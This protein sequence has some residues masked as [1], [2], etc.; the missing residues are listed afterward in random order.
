MAA[1]GA[2]DRCTELR[3]PW[4]DM[5]VPHVMAKQHDQLF[6]YNKHDVPF[7]TFVYLVLFLSFS[8]TPG[9]SRIKKT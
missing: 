3:S 4:K 9:A 2:D 8:D 7:V 1:P 5:R 6:V